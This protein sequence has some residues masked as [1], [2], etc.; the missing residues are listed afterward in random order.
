MFGFGKK[1]V[2]VR[3]EERIR[4]FKRDGDVLREF[5]LGDTGRKLLKILEDSICAGIL[6]GRGEV[7]DADKVTV[8]T[9]AK[10]GLLDLLC[11]HAGLDRN[12]GPDDGDVDTGVDDDD[13]TRGG[14]SSIQYAERADV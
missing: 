5:L 2:V 10:V 1:V 13:E 9:V 14:L 12:A 4:W 3:R 11:G 7:F 8:A 6:P